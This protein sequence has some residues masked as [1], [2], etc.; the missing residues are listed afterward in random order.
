[1]FNKIKIETLKEIEDLIEE[2]LES[3]LLELEENK[4]NDFDVIDGLI[5]KCSVLNNELVDILQKIGKAEYNKKIDSL[6]EELENKYLFN[7]NRK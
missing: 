4:Y 7:S 1:M 3:V 2:R 6:A 5:I